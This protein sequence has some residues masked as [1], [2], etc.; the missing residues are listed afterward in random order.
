[1]TTPPPNP[2]VLAA[3]NLAAR[4]PWP[5]R[6]AAALLRLLALVALLAGGAAT[7]LVE[8]RF[9]FAEAAWTA[10]VLGGPLERPSRTLTTEPVFLYQQVPG[11]DGSW[12]GLAVTTACTAAF[13]VGGVLVVGGLLLLSRRNSVPRVLAAAS[14]AV[15]LLATVN[16]ARMILIAEAQ[17]RWGAQGFGWTHTVVG[18]FL[19]VVTLGVCA[20]LFARL[21]LLRR[22]S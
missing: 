19:M 10:W 7:F 3:Q 22:G 2:A 5:R 1:M 8:E 17:A 13:Y 9:R 4:P 21:G 11:D 18:S 16:T 14:A 15:A 20:V 12:A 6:A